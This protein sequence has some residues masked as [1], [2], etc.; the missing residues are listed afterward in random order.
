MEKV[1]ELRCEVNSSREGFWR[2]FIDDELITELAEPIKPQTY[3]ITLS[4]DPECPGRW[5]YDHD[6][7]VV[8]QSL[9]EYVLWFNPLVW[10]SVWHE[11]PSVVTF[12]AVVFNRKQYAAAIGVDEKHLQISRLS[13]EQFYS[14]L[15]FKFPLPEDTLY[16]IPPLPNDPRGE[17]LIKNVFEHFFVA[18]PSPL[19]QHIDIAIPPE[20]WGEI[21]I[22]L[23]RDGFPEA[24][25]RVGRTPT[26]IA[27]GFVKY[28]S[29]PLWLC[30]EHVDRAFAP[31]IDAIIEGTNG[32]VK[33]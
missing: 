2:V 9:G 1:S 27:V 22:G 25:W 6:G 20:Q 15:H 21:R 8:V 10:E 31:F 5:A 14:V 30:G 11:S 28:P 16:T 18:S 17:R 29:F 24:V 23:E 12:D 19:S 13:P 33:D 3:E 4:S 26:G 32:N 7:Y